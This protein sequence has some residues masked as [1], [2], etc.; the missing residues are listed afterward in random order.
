MKLNI[1]Y[2]KTNLKMA[3]KILITTASVAIF[4]I[5]VFVFGT[6]INDD[7]EK[8]DSNKR[9]A[10][11]VIAAVDME[12]VDDLQKL[13]KSGISKYKSEDFSGAILIFKDV[14]NYDG[15]ASSPEWNQEQ[16]KL[17]LMAYTNLSKA[18]G[19]ISE[20]GLSYHYS[21]V[22]LQ[23]AIDISRGRERESFYRDQLHRKNFELAKILLLHSEKLKGSIEG[24]PVI[25]AIKYFNE[26]IN[27]NP[28]EP[29]YYAF[30][31]LALRMI[32]DIDGSCNDINMFNKIADEKTKSDA[33][34]NSSHCFSS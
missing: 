16:Q 27:I 30:R 14:V 31:S 33:N 17:I 11:A 7:K 29:L 9:L 20:Y 22:A 4:L 15:Y 6:V 32:N 3:K 25:D 8:R 34:I 1:N 19:E 28:T 26:A 5:L 10:Q 21:L 2:E 18:Y 24:D 12:V 23:T 13:M